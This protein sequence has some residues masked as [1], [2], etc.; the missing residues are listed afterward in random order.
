MKAISLWQPWATLWLLTDPDEKVYETRGWYTNYR[1]ALL[2]HAAK[3]R[4][5]EVREALED[6]P[7]LPETLKQ[8]GMTVSDL[9]F[10]AIIGRVDLVS[11]TRMDRM[12]QPSDREAMWGRWEPQ[13]FAWGRGS[14]P[15][16][17]GHPVDLSGAQGLFE[18]S[19]TE[20]RTAAPAL[21]VEPLEWWKTWLRRPRGCPLF[22]EARGMAAASAIARVALKTP[23]NIELQRVGAGERPELLA[24][25]VSVGDTRLYI[26]RSL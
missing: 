20:M 22:F 21:P 6:D 3:K 19:E 9:V 5:G 1:G 14:A 23:A 8:H 15:I 11:C 17:F 26:A 12:P 18:V 4:D 10:G 25:G 2:V 24:S 13:R 7:A 16:L